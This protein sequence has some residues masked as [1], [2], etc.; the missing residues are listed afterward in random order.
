MVA[1]YFSSAA[2]AFQET[3][4]GKAESGKARPEVQ[5]DTRGTGTSIAPEAP[6]GIEVRIPGLGKLGVLPKFD[7]GLELLYG[8]NDSKGSEQENDRLRPSE[9]DSPQIRGTLKHRF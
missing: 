3:T 9:D 8:M 4:Q 1:G 5:L 6:S 2:V 7:F